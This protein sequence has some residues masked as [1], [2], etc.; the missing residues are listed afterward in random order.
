[1]ELNELEKTII[2][3][4][5]LS[6]DMRKKN[7]YWLAKQNSLM[8]YEVFKLKK[9]H[10]HKLKAGGVITDLILIEMIAFVLAVKELIES[11]ELQNKKNRSNDLTGLRKIARNQAKQWKKTRKTPKRD[12]LLFM[13]NNIIA[14]IEAG[15]SDRKIAEKITSGKRYNISHTEISRFHRE[16]KGNGHVDK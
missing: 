7:M 5:L 8:V 16:L 9:N 13:Q 14:W 11:T 6:V 12:K 10:F 1:M 2:E 3:T 4:T 15:L